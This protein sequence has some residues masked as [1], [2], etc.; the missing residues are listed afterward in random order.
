[1]FQRS[2]LF[3]KFGPLNCYDQKVACRIQPPSGAP[4]RFALLEMRCSGSPTAFQ[5][6]LLKVFGAAVNGQDPVYIGTYKPCASRDK[7]PIKR[8][9]VC[10]NGCLSGGRF[11]DDA[12]FHV[13][14]SADFQRLLEGQHE[15]QI[16]MLIDVRRLEIEIQA[17]FSSHKAK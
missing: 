4:M 14:S 8:I 12:N 2:F 7:P 10:F 13:C 1:M 9:F 15:Y 17:E 5:P 11:R 3:S 6:T 16:N